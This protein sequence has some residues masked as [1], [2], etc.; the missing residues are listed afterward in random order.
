MSTPLHIQD[1]QDAARHD[2]LRLA[3]IKSGA[4]LIV[5][6]A[7]YP[8]HASAAIA[9]INVDLCTSESEVTVGSKIGRALGERMVA[10]Y[11][12]LGDQADKAGDH[13]NEPTTDGL[14]AWLTTQLDKMNATTPAPNHPDADLVGEAV[15]AIIRHL[16]RVGTLALPGHSQLT[17]DKAITHAKRL[18]TL[19]MSADW[20]KLQK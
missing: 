17:M 10:M 2:A 13:G 11:A 19:A 5:L 20:R 7:V 4:K 12:Y 9:G 18:A 1:Q 15:E 8:D 3:L 16:V 14:S 6:F